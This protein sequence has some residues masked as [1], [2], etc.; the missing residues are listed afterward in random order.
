LYQL[1]PCS[2]Y[3]KLGFNMN[4]IQSIMGRKFWGGVIQ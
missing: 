1:S 3:K 2:K 4:M